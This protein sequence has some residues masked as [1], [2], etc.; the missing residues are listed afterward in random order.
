[1]LG[2]LLAVVYGVAG[3]LHQRLLF[4]YSFVTSCVIMIHVLVVPSTSLCCCSISPHQQSSKAL[5]VD[6]NQLGGTAEYL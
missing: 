3:L 6:I 4:R 1:M 5:F 2:K